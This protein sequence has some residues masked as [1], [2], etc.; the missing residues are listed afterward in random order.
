MPVVNFIATTSNELKVYLHQYGLGEVETNS[1]VVI[2]EKLKN[3][4]SERV[5]W[6]PRPGPMQPRLLAVG[7]NEMPK[8]IAA[9]PPAPDLTV[10]DP[11][12]MPVSQTFWATVGDV[13]V[14]RETSLPLDAGA[15]QPFAVDPGQA[16]GPGVDVTLNLTYTDADGMVSPPRVQ[17][18]NV[19]APTVPPAP[20]INL[21]P[22]APGD[23]G[24]VTIEPDAPATP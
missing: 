5:K 19:P 23:F 2:C 7:E 3:L 6:P 14:A 16:G 21:P 1:V 4:R 9:F 8:I 18:F 13:E 15:C 12:K 10:T 11:D 17:T 20:V 24:N 22:D